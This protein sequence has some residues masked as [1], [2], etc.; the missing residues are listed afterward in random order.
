M[1]QPVSDARRAVFAAMLPLFLS[2]ATT[3]PLAVEEPGEVV[4]LST[5][6]S[7]RMT[8]DVDVDGRGPF[9]F[10]VDTGAQRTLI[11]TELARLL[12]L[13]AGRRAEL[14]SISG[15]G[16]IETVIIPRLNVSSR[17][18]SGIEAPAIARVH[19]GAMGILGIDSLAAQRVLLDFKRQTMTIHPS[20]EPEMDRDPDTIVVRAKSRFGQLVLV[21]ASADGQRVRVIVDT[22]AQVSIGN[23]ALRRKLMGRHRKK[24]Y[25]PINLISV[26]G[27]IR[28]ADYTTVDR[29]KI[30]GIE[31]K[32]LPIAFAD[33]HAFHALELIDQPAMLL[34]MDALRAFDRV[35]V[36]FAKRTV[37]FL[38]PDAARF[39]SPLRY[40]AKPAS[41]LASPSP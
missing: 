5:D 40:A 4:D 29:I 12:N 41:R 35:S 8:V 37:S 6:R 26:T 7:N 19:L 1:I 34:G 32:K 10:V 23:E 30:A 9:P 36:D 28:T 16:P 21:N 33:V 2:A 22:G 24:D 39:E 18:V 25:Q 11:S 3:P 31:M 14:H 15:S 38:L 27:G 20:A 17:P 13:P